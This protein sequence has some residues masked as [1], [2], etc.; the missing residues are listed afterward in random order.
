MSS[1]VSRP[2]FDAEAGAHS[3][4][5]PGAPPTR[6]RIL[7]AA[8]QLFADLGYE[9]TTIRAI[10]TAARVDPALVLHY[11]GNKDELFAA[12]LALPIDPSPA[13]PMLLAIDPASAG[14][15][16]TRAFLGLWEDLGER[17]AYM[18]IVRCGASNE[19]AAEIIRGVITRQV[20]EPIT[21][22][23]GLPQA[24]LRA[25]LV[26]SQFIGLVMA[27]Y[28]VRVEPLAS[29]DTET[30]VRAVAPNIQR[31]LTGDLGLEDPSSDSAES[32]H[33]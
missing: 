9:R 31:F 23:L 6:D 30:V 20:L 32:A 3:G 17:S 29:A 21:R 8:R 1:S 2:P 4:R 13:I 26:A 10:G 25:T 12:A 11:F 19:H 15:R 14:E 16:T 7:A 24:Q 5:R 18:A 33:D 22:A 28:L 27:R